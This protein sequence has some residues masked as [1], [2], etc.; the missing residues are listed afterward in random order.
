[1][2]RPP[3]DP[4][5]SRTVTQEP[6]ALTITGETFMS[7]VVEASARTPVLVDFWAP[8]CAPCRQLMPVLD[9]LAQE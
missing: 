2:T 7:E 5:R 9:R 3:Q 4:I 1:M 6:D 8:W